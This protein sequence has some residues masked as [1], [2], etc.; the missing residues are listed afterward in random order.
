MSGISDLLY[1]KVD[2]KA[3][4]YG[5]TDLP[6]VIAV[7]G[8]SH[9][10]QYAYETALYGHEGVRWY[11]D[12]DGNVVKNSIRSGRQPDGIFTLIE[13]GLLKNRKVSVVVFYE[14][15]LGDTDHQHLLRVYHNPNALNPLPQEIFDGVPQFVPVE[16]DGHIEMRWINSPPDE[17]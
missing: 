3:R 2:E 6:L 8:R 9:P 1:Y 11:R 7:W 5:N 17:N 12:R 14:C 15:R 16:V 4:K 10:D 13:D